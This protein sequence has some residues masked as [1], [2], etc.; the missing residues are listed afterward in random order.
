M[1]PPKLIY[2]KWYI[3]SIICGECHPKVIIFYASL[4]QPCRQAMQHHSLLRGEPHAVG[5]RLAGWGVQAPV[6]NKGGFK[7]NSTVIILT[8]QSLETGCFQAGVSLHRLTTRS[9]RGV[10]RPNSKKS[11]KKTQNT[12]PKKHKNKNKNKNG[13]SSCSS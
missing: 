8:H 13:C 12:N 7:L 6:R 2:R 1:L 3:M 11:S 10:K 5:C 4:A 9:A